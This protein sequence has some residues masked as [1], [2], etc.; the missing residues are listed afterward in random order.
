MNLLGGIVGACACTGITWEM[1]RLAL[2][3]LPASAARL[4]LVLLLLLAAVLGF[5]S[6][7]AIC[8]R[9]ARTREHLSLF[10]GLAGG[11]AGGLL[12]CAYAMT[13]TA[14]Y[15]ASYTTWP[16]DRLDQILVLLSYPVFGALG[17][18]MG[19]LLGWLLGLLLGSFLKIA[20]QPR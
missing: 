5:L 11:V 7:S 20:P 1:A 18:C 15:L 10:A 19:A 4:S 8:R 3:N 2:H 13:V 6:G 17:A 16:Q 9:A 14:A 12:G